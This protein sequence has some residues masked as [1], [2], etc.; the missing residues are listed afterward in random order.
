MIFLP[1]G[2]VLI[3][4]GVHELRTRPNKDELLSSGGC[5]LVA[6][7]VFLGF[8]IICLIVGAGT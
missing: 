3:I 1:C 2:V 5:G 4:W 6:G 7:I 8:G